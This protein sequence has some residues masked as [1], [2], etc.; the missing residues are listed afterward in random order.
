MAENVKEH[1]D[2]AVIGA[3]PAGLSAA[4]K[5]AEYD[6]D[7]RAANPD[8][9]PSH[10]LI[11]GSPL[12][13][14][15]I[16]RYQKG[17]HVM[18]EPG[19]LDLRSPLE[20]AAGKR[21]QILKSWDQ[22]ISETGINFRANCEVTKI[23]GS[24]GNFEIHCA[25][26]NTISANNV[27]LSIGTQGN[28]RR[29]GVDGDNSHFV[30][31]QLD[32]PDEYHDEDIIVV[33][34]GDAAI[35]NALALAKNN[36]VVIVNRKNEFTR[37]KQGNLDNVLEAINDRNMAFS[38][39]YDASV[40][41][42]SVPPP[43]SVGTVVLNTARGD[44]TLPCHRVIA[45][46]GSIPPRQF[47]ESCGIALPNKDPE[48]I[49]ELDGQYQ[50]NV[51]GLYI[52]GALAGYPLI[53]Q[54]MNQ[55]YD[56]IEY[57]KGKAVKPVDHPLLALKFSLL[58]YLADVDDILA[59]YQQR[60]PMFSRMN[61]LAFRELIMESD[62][63]YC[64]SDAQQLNSLQSQGASISQ[65]RIRDIESARSAD[66]QRRQSAGLAIKPVTPISPPVITKLLRSGDFIYR[67]NDYSNSFFTII[68]GQV[69]L[70]SAEGSDTIL[71][72]GQFFGEMSLLSGRPRIGNAVASNDTILIETPRRTMAKLMAANDEVAK[73][74]E[75]VF[76]QRTLQQFFTP[77]G[78]YVDLRDIAKQVKT[79]HFNTGKYIYKEDDA[80]E[81]L[82]LIRSGTIALSRLENGKEIAIG[83]LH[84]GQ[85]FGQMA[86]MGDPTRRES[87]YAA[88][89]S[90]VIEISRQP[91][92]ALLSKSPES[93]TRLQ[94]ETS[95]QLKST[96]ELAALPEQASLMSF[97]LAQG[98]GEGTNVLLIDENLCVGCDNCET[99]CAETHKGIS[100]LDRKAG[101][102]F[103]NINLPIACR[104]CEQ[105][106]CM[107]ECPPNA[108][109][110]E[111]SGEVYIND[112]C[113]GCGNCETNCPY[114]VIKLSYQLPEKPPFLSWLFGGVG[115]GPG[116]DKNATPSNMA[117]EIGKKAVKCD[118]C[119]DRPA[120][121]ACVQYCPTGAAQR[122]EPAEF[123]NVL[124]L[125]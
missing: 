74:I 114:G 112:S 25:D 29:L 79:S 108:I 48:A 40:K 4:A 51:P 115:P 18:D 2:I 3:G 107:K 92:L 43:G 98:T 88:V 120:G 60:V 6:L 28:P 118:A 46:L 5:A 95:K 82:Y 32:D 113:I 9:T 85:I 104:H 20:F 39:R 70:S 100:R 72:P 106:H 33:G 37:A 119:V 31:Y 23:T 71:G 11:E 10:I 102:R 15:T 87:A 64:V 86:L 94:T 45:R 101:V 123:I 75:T 103:A 65:E 52:I 77:Q 84:S 26:G 38:C 50:C 35:E 17:K 27:V 90:E 47:V 56:V 36:R 30:Q 19:Y 109:H 122:M 81:H 53:K 125:R 55:G 121:P 12:H 89:R 54:G 57:I 16:Q 105:P 7:A 34:A 62:I 78:S 117:K 59:L 58:P 76:L 1:F 63:R 99:A 96:A 49:P 41:S 111:S 68:E 124:N 42:L 66:I 61:A 73:G 93:I 67:H 21:E 24:R 97:L 80:G 110:R 13:A 83:Q 91:F 69:T 8:H 44:E 22:G 116:E 14:N